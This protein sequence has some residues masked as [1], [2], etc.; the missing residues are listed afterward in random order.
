MH[1]TNGDLL[2]RSRTLAWLVIAAAIGIEALDLL[3]RSFNTTAPILRGTLW[4]VFTDVL[5]SARAIALALAGAALLTRAGTALRVVA[6][7][8]V[9]ALYGAYTAAAS[10]GAEFTRTSNALFLAAVFGSA[11]NFAATRYV[12][13]YPQPV[14]RLTLHP[15]L[16]LFT[17][18]QPLLLLCAVPLVAYFIPALRGG[19]LGLWATALVVLQ[20]AYLYV[21]LQQVTADERLRQLWLMAGLALILLINILYPLLGNAL[22]AIGQDVD[23]MPLL[24]V[25]YESAQWLPLACIAAALFLYRDRDPAVLVQQIFVRGFAVA[26]TLLI[27]FI[28]QSLIGVVIVAV[29]LAALGFKPI[30]SAARRVL[31]LP[32]LDTTN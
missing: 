3:L 9:L 28:V 22:Q 17:R 6:A 5:S 30:Y 29:V 26:G 1:Q 14:A 31:R 16:A 11:L 27:F 2:R 32:A 23:P 4:F 25:L 21:N 10:A 24:W 13:L 12:Q 20:L 8:L 18:T 7:A 15:W 19:M